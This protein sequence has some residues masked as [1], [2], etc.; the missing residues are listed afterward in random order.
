MLYTDRADAW[1]AKPYLERAIAIRRNLRDV[2]GESSALTVLALMLKNLGE[3]EEALKIYRDELRGLKLGPQRRAIVLTELASL[4]TNLGKPDDAFRCLQEAFA[5]QKQGG[6]LRSQANTLVGFGRAYASKKDLENTL[7]SYQAALAIYRTQNDLR[8]QATTLMNIG[9]TLGSLGRYDDATDASGRALSLAR[10]LKQPIL[11]GGSLLGLAWTERL[12]GDLSRSEAT[13][14][15][16]S[17][18]DRVDA[19]RDQGPGLSFVL[20]FNSAG[21][22]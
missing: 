15:R 11:E 21:H 3:Y 12:R 5:L 19:E 8:A 20:F 2:E 22:L 6:D 1:N 4:Y 13:G 18:T 16:G 14:R 17:G 7:A 9:W 10:Q